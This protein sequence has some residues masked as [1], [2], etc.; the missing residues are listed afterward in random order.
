MAVQIFRIQGT[1]DRIKRTYR[2]SQEIRALNE[3]NAREQLYEML[4]SC[5]RVKRSRIII[6]KIEVIQPQEA[7]KPL[8][9]KLSGIE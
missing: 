9:R 7:E 3:E 6:K 5:H 1:Y 4:G 8:I 2:F